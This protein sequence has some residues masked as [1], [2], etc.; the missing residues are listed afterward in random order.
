MVG[1]EWIGKTVGS[2]IAK[3]ILDAGITGVV[4]QLSSSEIEKA[5]DVALNQ[6]QTKV[7]E[8]VPSLNADEMY[9]ATNEY[10]YSPSCQ[11]AGRFSMADYKLRECKG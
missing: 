3:K 7:G 9:F 4:Q 6:T 5:L 1:V 2:V 8:L 10:I 11:I